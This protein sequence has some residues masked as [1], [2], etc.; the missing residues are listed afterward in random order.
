MKDL[1]IIA[2]VLLAAALIFGFITPDDIAQLLGELR[3]SD[4]IERM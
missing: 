2:G 1:L 4:L 3:F